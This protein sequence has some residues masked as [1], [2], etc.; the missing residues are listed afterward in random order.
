MQLP[1]HSET[2]HDV[3]F[4]LCNEA[5]HYI[6]VTYCIALIY[7]YLTKWIQQVITSAFKVRKFSFTLNNKV[8]HTFYL[9]QFNPSKYYLNLLTAWCFLE[10]TWSNTAC[11][12]ALSL[13]SDS[14]TCYQIIILYL[15]F[16]E[17]YPEFVSVFHL[18]CCHPQWLCSF[19]YSQQTLKISVKN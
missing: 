1:L 17:A 3:T 6:I 14:T 2:K 18:L 16:L 5:M 7:M 12:T 10:N 4:T 11:I 13:Q 19:H 8:L 9:Q 15:L